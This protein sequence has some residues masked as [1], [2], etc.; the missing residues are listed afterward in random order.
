MQFPID[1]LMDEKNCYDYLS[2]V[3]HPEG[4]HCP[5]GHLLPKDQ[6]PHDRHRDPFFD[7]KCRDCGAVYNI[8]TGS[9]WLKTHYS[10][11]KIVLIMRGFIQGV[12][13][14]HLAKELG[15]DRTNLLKIRHKVL[16]WAEIHLLRSPLPDKVTE[17]D[18]MFQN[19]GEKGEKHDDPDDP[20]RYRANKERGAGTMENDR[21]PILG[22]IGRESGKIHL[23]VCNNTKQDTIQRQVE[24]DTIT[25]TKV[26]T[27]ESSAYEHIDE[28]GRGHATV[29]H[30]KKEWARD[31][32][33]D[34]VREVH[35]NTNEG[36]WTGLRNYL[37]PFR[38]L[39]KK[40]LSIYVAMFE[41][42]HN[43]KK[44]TSEFLKTLMVPSFTFNPT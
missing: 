1:E 32:D 21:P 14:Q 13:T 43:L 19:A 33:G 24:N 42:T 3:L 6:K 12:P 18:E 23:T 38:G 28:T 40:F 36:L 30:S 7:Y 41:W 25:T 10:C 29:C 17:S 31:D 26:N 37:R 39:H 4:V 35:C 11:I 16:K 8:Y 15:L 20:P 27:D 34:G 2:S 5:N 22:V 9:I 44:I